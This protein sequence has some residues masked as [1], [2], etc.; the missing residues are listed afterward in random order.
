VVAR[1][2]ARYGQGEVDGE[3]LMNGDGEEVADGVQQT[4]EISKTWS[5]LSEASRG[6]GDVRLESSAASAIVGV[7]E[8]LQQ[9]AR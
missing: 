4:T 7:L 8:K 5:L 9:R 1:S 2:P 6:E 3:L